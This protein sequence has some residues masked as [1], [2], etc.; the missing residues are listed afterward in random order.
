MFNVYVDI[1]SKTPEP[2][3]DE[4]DYFPYTQLVDNNPISANYT[5]NVSEAAKTTEHAPPVRK[6]FIWRI[7]W[8]TSD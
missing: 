8:K 3:K 5:R 4:K 6:I 1:N 2:E 7:Y